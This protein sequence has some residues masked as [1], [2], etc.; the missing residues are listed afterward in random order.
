MKMKHTPEESDIPS[1]ADAVGAGESAIEHHLDVVAHASG[2]SEQEARDLD[3]FV[4]AE[5]WGG[6]EDTDGED[7]YPIEEPLSGEG[8]GDDEGE[9]DTEGVAKQ[10]ADEDSAGET[11]EAAGGYKSS[12]DGEDTRKG[13]SGS[14]SET[15]DDARNG[16]VRRVKAPESIT[17][18]VHATVQRKRRGAGGAGAVNRSRN[19][20]K[21]KFKGKVLYKHRDY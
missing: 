11:D 6:G 19:H 1:F 17:K 18:R 7:D 8:E 9:G 16:R 2:F 3:A 20:Q 10:E 13:A 14:D 12:Q 15:G 4:S 5:G 21:I